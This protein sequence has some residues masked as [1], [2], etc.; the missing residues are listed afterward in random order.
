MKHKKL[1]AILTLVC[2]ML[3]LMPVAAMAEENALQ[4]AIEN[5]E[6]NITLA[7]G[8]FT[9]PSS[10]TSASITIT[11]VEGT[12]I[13]VTNGAYL[14]NATL[15]F[16]NVAFKVG[17]GYVY[18]ANG[19]QGSDYAALYSPNVTYKNCTFSG[20]MRVGRDGAQFIN[21]TFKDLGNDYIWTYGN[22]VTFDG[23]TFNTAGKAILIYSDGGN[24]VSTVSVKNCTFNA[25]AG[26]KAG[27]IAN[28]N[29]AA[30]EIHNY[31]NGVDLTTTD[32]TYNS[33]F[34]GEWRIKTYETNKPDVIVN[35]VEYTT[36]AIDGKTMTIDADKNVTVLEPVATVG[37]TPYATLQDALNVAA[38]G[39]GNVTVEILKDIDLKNVDWDPVT[40]SAPSYPC[41]TVN[42]NE[43]TITGLNDM[44]FDA[45]WAGDSGLIINDLTIKDSNI[46]HDENDTQGNV[47]VGAFIGYPQASETI[48]LNNC[49]LVDSKV[50]GGHW[51]GGLIGMAGGYNGNDG[52]VFMNLTIKDCSVTGSTITG[53][54][55]VGGVIGH[56]SCAAWTNVVITDTEVKNNTITSTGDSNV[57]AGTVMGTI[58]A[59]GQPTEVNAVTKTGG[60]E[61][62]VVENGNTVTSNGTTIT[63]VYGRQGTETGRLIITGGSY[64]NYP[65]EKEVAY[66]KIKDDYCV[67]IA[68]PY[69]VSATHTAGNPV[70]ENR[71]EA[72]YSAPGSYDS[73]VYC[74]VC[75]VEMS[76]EAKAIPQLE[77][78]YIP[79][80]DIPV[81]GGGSSSSTSTPKVE[82]ETTVT[83]S[84]TKVETTTETKSDGTKVETTTTTT[85]SGETTKVETTTETN[86]EGTKVETTV[87]TDSKGE[88]STTVTATLDN[89]SAVTN[90]DKAVEVEVTKV[91]EKVVETVQEAVKADETVNVV[92]DADNAVSVSAT[93]ASTGAAQTDFVQPMSVNVPVDT[94]VLNNVEDTSKL[95]LAKVV[96]NEDGTTELVYMGGSYDEETGTFNAKVD[97]DGD[98]ILVEKADLV[99]IELTIDD[100][101]VK[102]N[103]KHQELDVAPAIN[104]EA[105]RT[106]LPLRYLGEALGFGIDWN[107][108]VVTITKDGVSFSLTIGVEIPG[109]GTPYIDSDRTMVSARYISEMLGANVIWDPVDRQVIVVK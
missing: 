93:N 43:H 41:V 75:G 102:H 56:G 63:T 25:T 17:T 37:G 76:R 32:N 52:P 85:A 20:P 42:G 82:T 12:T 61:V 60:V 78:P 70:E 69:T 62:N 74:S 46:V 89:G 87:T 23:C 26:A 40:V 95:T 58:G 8:T 108:N 55:S 94:T 11:G 96:T 91:E 15:T 2:F 21:C 22:D 44:L 73:V 53:K 36:I 64:I 24:E 9:M 45:T 10:T 30:I 72:S 54:G 101:T 31:G 104:A 107:N 28:Q 50:E 35:E 109:Y 39:S 18:G 71:V 80:V 105:G 98:Y 67:S 38:A 5:G 13:D 29:C 57:K 27:A 16:E 106:E 83:P 3:T 49:H 33:N 97:E 7:A 103:D 88:T 100:T 4:T 84:G 66:A 86:K 81:S 68:S 99:K 59:A 14:D 77:I 65:I 48:T 92:G 47:G 90:S 1:F 79:S 34:S 51:T 19:V 6:T